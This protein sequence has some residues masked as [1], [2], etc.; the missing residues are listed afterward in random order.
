MDL[1]FV[2]LYLHKNQIRGTIPADI[3]KLTNL[4]K[5]D[6]A[7]N[8]LEGSCALLS[9]PRGESRSLRVVL[10]FTRPLPLRRASPAG[11]V[12]SE[13]KQL[14]RLKGLNLTANPV[15][16]HTLEKPPGCPLD[17]YGDMD[18]RSKDKVAAFLRCLA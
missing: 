8:K 14:T 16:H 1:V 4:K 9:P 17:S 3:G 2:V 12:P 7:V 15:Y 10:S 5:L 18:Y 11:R 6:L 13:L